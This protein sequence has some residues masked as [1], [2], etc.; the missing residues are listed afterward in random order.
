MVDGTLQKYIRTKTNKNWVKSLFSHLLSGGRGSLQLHKYEYQYQR[1]SAQIVLSAWKTVRDFVC[2]IIEKM[3]Y[4]C[5]VPSLL[6]ILVQCS[7]YEAELVLYFVPGSEMKQ[8]IRSHQQPPVHCS[9]HHFVP[10]SEMKENNISK[11]WK[12]TIYHIKRKQYI[13]STA[14]SALQCTSFL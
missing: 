13:T 11:K 8:N 3:Q 1:S 2:S 12:K 5:K 6:N 9:A 4:Q 14:Y 7:Q 10:G